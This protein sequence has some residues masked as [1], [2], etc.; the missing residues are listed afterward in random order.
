MV[1]NSANA[2]CQNLGFLSVFPETG[3]YVGGYLVTNAWG[4]PLEFRLSSAVQPN[5]VQQILYGEALPRY[6]CGELIGKTLIDKTATPVGWVMVDNPLSLDLRRSLAVPVCLWH[7]TATPGDSMP[8]LMVQSRVYCHGD[9]PEDVAW[10]RESLDA[11]G[12]FDLGEP[13]ARIREAMTEAR[14]QGVTL[15]S[16]AA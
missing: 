10:F 8:G 16:A 15:R 4:R 1:P 12:A 3:G 14:K 5:K 11:L 6:L 7:N 2:P 9:Y 13:F